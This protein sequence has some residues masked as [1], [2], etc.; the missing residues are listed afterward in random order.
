M[1]KITSVV[2]LLLSNHVL[3]STFLLVPGL[4][5]LSFPSHLGFYSINSKGDSCDKYSVNASICNVSEANSIAGIVGARVGG[6]VVQ[7]IMHFIAYNIRSTTLS[8]DLYKEMVKTR[9]IN[10]ATLKALQGK[11][12]D[13]Q[14]R[15]GSEDMLVLQRVPRSST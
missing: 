4:P 10:E 8:I 1:M 13:V 6:I 7:L 3:E 12:Q 14:S 15:S 11:L 5:R 9:E 2:M